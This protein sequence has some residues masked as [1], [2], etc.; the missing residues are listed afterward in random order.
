MA[1]LKLVVV[2]SLFSVVLI[3]LPIR[4]LRAC[5]DVLEVFNILLSFPFQTK[6]TDNPILKLL[7]EPKRRMH[8]NVVLI[9]SVGIVKAQELSEYNGNVEINLITTGGSDC[10]ESSP[11]K[12]TFPALLS[13]PRKSYNTF[14]LSS[15]NAVEKE[16]VYSQ[17][18][19]GL[20]K[21]VCIQF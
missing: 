18:N 12:E 21:Q 2:F 8:A 14:I 3:K 15:S 20:T 6:R 4:Y 19:A 13:K 7:R 11:N 10:G 1:L 5:P 9:Q 16:D 17:R